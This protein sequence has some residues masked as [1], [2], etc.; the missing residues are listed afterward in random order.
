MTGQGSRKELYHLNIN[1]THNKDLT[2]ADVAK[3]KAPLSIVYQRIAHLNC[4]AIRRMT[5]KNIVDGL[6][7]QDS[8]TP[9]DPCNGC[10]YG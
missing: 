4:R 3:K 6:D 9:P 8:K 5:E 1:V 7:L 10:I 2:T